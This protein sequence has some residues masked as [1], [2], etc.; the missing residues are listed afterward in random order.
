MLSDEIYLKY[1]VRFILLNIDIKFI[2]EKR[3]NK[4]GRVCREKYVAKER[5]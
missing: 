2:Q 3:F 4:P 5:I 1:F